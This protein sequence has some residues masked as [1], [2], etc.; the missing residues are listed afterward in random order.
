MCYS[1]SYVSRR[2]PSWSH[3]IISILKIDTPG[4]YW[5]VL[6]KLSATTIDNVG[7]LLISLVA[8]GAGEIAISR[9][10]LKNTH[11]N[12]SLINACSVEDQ[13]GLCVAA[14]YNLNICSS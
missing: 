4:F 3:W 14:K 5:R 13:A 11:S 10:T 7:L 1:K 9:F 8:E 12:I 2:N 6:W